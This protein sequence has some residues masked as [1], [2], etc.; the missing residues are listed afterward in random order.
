[1]VLIKRNDIILL[2]PVPAPKPN[3]AGIPKLKKGRFPEAFPVREFPVLN[4]N[5][6]LIKKFI[7]IKGVI[8]ADHICD[9]YPS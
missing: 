8:W 1:M 4:P 5:R 3:C 2:F 9:V 7:A 6:Q